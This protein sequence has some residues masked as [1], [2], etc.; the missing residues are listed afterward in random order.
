MMGTGEDSSSLERG[1][2]SESERKRETKREVGDYFPERRR[3]MSPP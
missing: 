2:E 3:L 1:R